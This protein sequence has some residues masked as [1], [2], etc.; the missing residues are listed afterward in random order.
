[1]HSIKTV[2]KYK[3][4]LSESSA[5]RTP[6]F[7]HSRWMLL[8]IFFLSLSAAAAE[9][10]LDSYLALSVLTKWRKIKSNIILFSK[11][12]FNLYS[13]LLII[14]WLNDHYSSAACGS[15]I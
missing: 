3:P 13:F 2:A 14:H 9:I 11:I 1:M 4:I 8:F 10:V 12:A 5:I 6:L 7:E 15:L